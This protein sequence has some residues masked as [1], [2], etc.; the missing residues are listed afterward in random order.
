MIQ[1][2]KNFISPNNPLM[3]QQ[4]IN[5]ST[6]PTFSKPVCCEEATDVSE[7]TC[8]TNTSGL[9]AQMQPTPPPTSNDYG[10]S[11]S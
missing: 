7:L 6:T 10:R 11:Y 5:T 1:V 2:A 4:E 9:P 3:S 8:T